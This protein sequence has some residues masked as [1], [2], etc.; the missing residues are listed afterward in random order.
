MTQIGHKRPGAVG[1][2]GAKPGP[3][4]TEANNK[5]AVLAKW[6]NLEMAGDKP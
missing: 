6:I 2:P 5:A 1:G 3:S 4:I